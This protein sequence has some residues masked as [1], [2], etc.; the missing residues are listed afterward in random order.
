MKD[1][2]E[3]DKKLELLKAAGDYLPELQ[4]LMQDSVIEEAG[5][6][7]IDSE[8]VDSSAGDKTVSDHKQSN[9]ELKILKEFE[10]HKRKTS[11]LAVKTDSTQPSKSK[12]DSNLTT[13]RESNHIKTSEN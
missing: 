4:G 12:M 10:E 7:D 2:T 3:E 11:G 8:K 5:L 6:S 9:F 13:A 1:L